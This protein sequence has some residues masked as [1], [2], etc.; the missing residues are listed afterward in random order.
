MVVL[1][2]GGKGGRNVVLRFKTPSI[3]IAYDWQWEGTHIE[4][5]IDFLDRAGYKKKNLIFYVLHNFFDE[6]YKK[7]DT[8]ADFIHSLQD[9][10]KW[11]ASAYPMRY[12][13][14]NSL[15]RRGFVSPLWTEEQLE[16]IADAR[17]VLGYA[18]TFVNYRAL[19]NKIIEAT[20]FEEALFLRPKASELANQKRIPTPM[21][22]GY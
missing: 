21:T 2:R 12:I 5:V 3:H 19:A 4:K 7:G 9:L 10:M 16:M 11:G 1:F 18:G 14:L 8:P 20:T 22:E 15:T 6:Q 17:R 13:P